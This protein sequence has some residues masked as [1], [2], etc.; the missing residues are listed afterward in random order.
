MALSNSTAEHTDP[1]RNWVEVQARN[2]LRLKTIC[3]PE[4]ALDCCSR[5]IGPIVIV[6]YERYSRL[7]GQFQSGFGSPWVGDIGATSK[8]VEGVELR[9]S[10]IRLIELADDQILKNLPK[11]D[12]VCAEAIKLR[13]TDNPKSLTMIDTVLIADAEYHLNFSGQANIKAKS[14]AAKEIAARANMSIDL[15][16]KDSSVIL[17]SISCGVSKTITCWLFKGSRYRASA[18]R[19]SEAS[20]RKVAQSKLSKPTDKPAA[21]STEWLSKIAWTSQ[22]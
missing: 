3:S 14:D 12:K 20:C 18:A 13:Y 21:A 11:R 15:D 19:L 6:R 2:P 16:R 5:T 10:K 7:H 1:A 9:L 4:T 17:G 8:T 22:L